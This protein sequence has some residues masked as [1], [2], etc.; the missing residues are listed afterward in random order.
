MGTLLDPEVLHTRHR[1]SYQQIESLYKFSNMDEILREKMEQFEKFGHFMKIAS[2]FD[3][4]GLWFIPLKGPLLSFRIY[5]DPTVRISKDFDFLMVEESIPLAIKSLE[6]L[7]YQAENFPWP[8]ST[9]RQRFIMKQLNQF[10]L[11]HPTNQT[12]VELHWRLLDFPV[13]SADRVNGMIK[14]NLD[15]TSMG[16]QSFTMFNAEFELLYL[17]IHGS[18]HAWSRLKWLVDVK[19]MLSALR[20]DN[21]RFIWLMSQLCAEKPVAVCNA[22]LR[23]FF[24]GTVL[25]PGGQHRGKFLSE[26]GALQMTRDQDIPTTPPFN[27][28]RYILF[29]MK[30]FPGMHYKLNTLQLFSVSDQDLRHTW[31]PPFVVCYLLYRPFGYLSRIYKA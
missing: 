6:N 31:I 13:T 26:F 22:L 5:G 3:N 4:A 8:Q 24:P 1:L 21:Q 11:I 17:V 29:R 14:E 19:D 16:G 23:R 2:T 12:S 30:L 9:F 28:I 10:S 18:L 25:L 15:T 20:I 27:F 7:G